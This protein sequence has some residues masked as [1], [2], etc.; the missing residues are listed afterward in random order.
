MPDLGASLALSLIL[1]IGPGIS[2][3][4][5][6]AIVTAGTLLGYAVP[7]GLAIGAQAY[8]AQQLN[9]LRQTQPTNDPNGLQQIIK[10]SIPPQRLVLGRA[11]TGGAMFFYRAK[12]PYIWYGLLL[13]AHEI[14]GFEN[15]FMNGHTVFIDENGF[16]TS[17][18]FRDGD[19][20][21]IEVSFRSGTLDQ[22]IDPIIARDFPDM[23]ATF[24][25]RGHA[26]M[27]IKA[28]YGF[29][30]GFE[31]QFEDHKRVYGDQGSLQPMVRI[32]GARLPDLRK[33]GVALGDKST[34]VWS[35]NAP[36]CLMRHLIHGWPDTRLLDPSRLDWDAFMR[37]ADE[38]DR[39][40]VS[41]DGTTFRR[42]TV[43]GI[44]QST[45]SPWDVIENFKIAMGGHLI[46]DR[47]KVY[48]VI[49][50]K[51]EPV[52]TLHQQMI[53]GGLE[54]A[55]EPRDRELVNI[56]KPTFIA[57]DRE[58]QEV[59]GP[60][61][62]RADLIANDNKAREISIRGAFVEDH[63]RMQRVASANLNWARNGKTLTVGATIEALSWM[64]GKTYRVHLLGSLAR[65]NGTY[66]LISKQWDDRLRGYR[67]SFVGYDPEATWFDPQSEQ[68][69]EL[70]PD[71]VNAEAA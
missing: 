69:F 16:A 38:C 58:Y 15:L 13:A 27:V 7:V 26:T 24:R 49:R 52:A 61:L 45:D 25:Q 21:Y 5:A 54:Y 4:A 67:L 44:V 51:R 29:G 20:K 17:V 62:R 8:Q 35:D 40:E 30:A 22:A 11:T 14:D 2:G 66:E 43:N 46:I 68:D 19:N 28:H 9:R 57:P 47:G 18:P 31:E 10:Q 37:A 71:V 64:V 1:S 36:L 6:T 50:N 12:K 3:A 63:R 23:P 65:V 32:R 33:A 70:D 39:W 60:T 55:S 53:V 41:K 42:H 56:V 34:W 48:P 59:A